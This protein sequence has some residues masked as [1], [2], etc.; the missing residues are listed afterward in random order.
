MLYGR[1]AAPHRA[2]HS[3]VRVRVR[4]DVH[5]GVPRVVANRQKLCFRELQILQAVRRRRHAAAGHHL[6]VP[7]AFSDLVAHRSAAGVHAVAHARDGEVAALAR[8]R[9]QRDVARLAEISV[10]SGD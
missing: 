8:A 5:A 7:R 3:L 9:I 2:A 1:H 4:G 6:D 10:A